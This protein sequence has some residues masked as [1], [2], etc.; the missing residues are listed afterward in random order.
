MFVKRTTRLYQRK[1][2]NATPAKKQRYA[3][4]EFM[5]DDFFSSKGELNV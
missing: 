3:I 5:R 4:I 2:Q 1:K